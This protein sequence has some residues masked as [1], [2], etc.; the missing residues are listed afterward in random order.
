MTDS[1]KKAN[2]MIGKCSQPQRDAFQQMKSLGHVI[3]NP[4]LFKKSGGKYPQEFIGYNKCHLRA[5]MNVSTRAAQEA[6]EQK[7]PASNV[8]GVQNV[9]EKYGEK[10]MN[11]Y[12]ASSS[13]TGWR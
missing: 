5:L 10:R 13:S 9:L 6:R 7:I 4:Q 2:D 8:A 1:E 3:R 12:F 11:R